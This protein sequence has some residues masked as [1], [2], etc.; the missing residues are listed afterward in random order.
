MTFVDEDPDDE[1]MFVPLPPATP[2][3]ATPSSAR[4]AARTPKSGGSAVRM[5]KRKLNSA[6]K[7]ASE[8]KKDKKDRKT[9]S[10]AGRPRQR[11][12]YKCGKCGY[13]PKKEKVRDK[14]PIHLEANADSDTPL[15]SMIALR[16]LRIGPTPARPL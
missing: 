12:E 7:T 16:S 1:E 14:D 13:Y 11:G 5:D 9:Y 15:C 10:T 2:D 6:E 4:R 8:R 3:P